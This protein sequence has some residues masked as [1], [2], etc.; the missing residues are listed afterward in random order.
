MKRGLY[1]KVSG[2]VLLVALA[3]VLL[4]VGLIMSWVLRAGLGW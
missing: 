3:G 2:G 1:I 4:M